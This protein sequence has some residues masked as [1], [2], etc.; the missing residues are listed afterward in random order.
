MSAQSSMRTV[1]GRT[2]HVV[3]VGAGLAGLS[4]ALQL[5]GRGRA[6]TLSNATPTRAAGWAG[7]TFAAT[8][9][10]PARRC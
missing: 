1:T 4:A 2:D 7:P 9:S 3:V 5:I 10:I 8:A 6:V